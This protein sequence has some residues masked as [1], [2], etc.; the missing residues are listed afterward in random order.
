MGSR[1]LYMHLETD[2]TRIHPVMSDLE[3]LELCVSSKMAPW[4]IS[5]LHCCHYGPYQIDLLFLRVLYHI[6]ELGGRLEN[7][8]EYHRRA[9]LHRHT[10]VC[11]ISICR[12]A[13]CTIAMCFVSFMF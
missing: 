5:Q 11:K 9:P 12:H 8:K 3:L 2:T 4:E 10:W 1:I 7:E 13:C 6:F